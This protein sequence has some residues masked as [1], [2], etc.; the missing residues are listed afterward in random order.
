MLV[1]SHIDNITA[2]ALGEALNFRNM[3]KGEYK[4]FLKCRGEGGKKKIKD[5]LRTKWKVLEPSK[6]TSRMLHTTNDQ[7][8]ATDKAT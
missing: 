3:W 6:N 7:L 4:I 8:L 1:T 5:V 2:A